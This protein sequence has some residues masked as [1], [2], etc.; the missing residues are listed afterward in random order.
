MPIYEYK[1]TKCMF[2]IEYLDSSYTDVHEEC[3]ECNTKSLKRLISLG[4][5]QLK[6]D[7]WFKSTNK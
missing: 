4:S 1:C 5:F 7:G 3:P 2:M 6:G